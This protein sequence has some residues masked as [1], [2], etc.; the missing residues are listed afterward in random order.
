MARLV[1]WADVV[2]MGVDY[3]R[4]HVYKLIEAGL[5]PAPAA[6][7]YRALWHESDVRAWLEKRRREYGQRGGPSVH[8]PAIPGLGRGQKTPGIL[9]FVTPDGYELVGAKPGQ[10]GVVHFKGRQCARCGYR[11]NHG[12]LASDVHCV[13]A[14]C[15]LT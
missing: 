2:R 1:A 13:T 10:V 6:R 4:N 7:G 9:C 5:F 14:D 11:L 12:D 8:I 15:P 3:T